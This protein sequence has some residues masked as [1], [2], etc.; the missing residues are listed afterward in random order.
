MID[1]TTKDGTYTDTVTGDDLY[2]AAKKILDKCV[3]KPSYPGG[4][5]G[6]LGESLS[7]VLHMQVMC[8]RYSY[9]YLAQSISCLPTVN[10]FTL[11][12]IFSM[13]KNRYHALSSSYLSPPILF[14]LTINC[15]KAYLFSRIACF[16]PEPH[17]PIQGKKGNLLLDIR[18]Y[19]PNVICHD[20]ISNSA[21][22]TQAIIDGIPSPSSSQVWS[23]G[24]RSSTPPPS[25][26]TPYR[27]SPFS[28]HG[29]GMLLPDLLT[30]LHHYPSSH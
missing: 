14:Y 27:V 22:S 9:N 25:I 26:I 11:L 8:P 15:R 10:L 23:F 12:S 19:E 13:D 30:A 7:M 3:V 20:P 4:L 2:W 28:A 16:A 5:L 21:K 24:R 6:D 29:V 1:I 18:R 17:S